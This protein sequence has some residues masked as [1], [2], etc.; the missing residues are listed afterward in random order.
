MANNLQRQIL[1]D[2]WRNVSVK[3]VGVL[4]TSD[5]NLT[6]ALALSDLQPG[7][8]MRTLVGLRLDMVAWSVNGGLTAI[9]EWNA[10]S[11]QFIVALTDSQRIKANKSGPF[12][13][14]RDVTG[15]DGSINLKT[16]GYTP[17]RPVGYTLQ[18]NFV[19]IY[20]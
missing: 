2:G 8:P 3:W 10:S 20:E 14:N 18:C 19:K 9:L 13:P 4:D 15:Y 11:P 12:R 17:G 7:D 5:V 1:L 16:V 6:P